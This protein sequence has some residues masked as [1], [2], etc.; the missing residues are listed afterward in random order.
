MSVAFYIENSYKVSELITNKYSTSFSLATSVLEKEKRKAIYAIYGFVRLAD[1]I[2]DS[3]HTYDKPFLLAKLNEDQAYAM[4]N[5]ISTNLILASFVDTVKKYR[6]K[7]EHIDAFMQSM[8]YDLTKTNYT[9]TSDL[10]HYIYGSAD[11]VG[12]M[13]LTVFCN[14]NEALYNELEYPAQ[15]LGSAFQKV[16]F[17]R[18]LREDTGDLGRNYFPEISVDKFSKETKSLIEKS[19]QQDFDEAFTGIKRLPGRSKL[20]VGLA[21]YYYLSLFNKIKRASPDKILSMRV[22][23]SNLIKYLI[24]IRVGILYKLK[25]I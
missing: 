9:E 24:I 5:G 2:V 8:E 10:N 15:K 19:I 11:V 23:I 22:R 12:L 13:C 17:I 18:D 14:G 3:L 21:Y 4:Q 25:F 6:I 7:K 16:N 1:E 20:A